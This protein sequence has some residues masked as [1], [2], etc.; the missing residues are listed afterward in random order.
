MSFRVPLW[1][2]DAFLNRHVAKVR[3][4]FSGAA[5]MAAAALAVFAVVLLAFNASAVASQ[6][7]SKLGGVT[8]NGAMWLALA[9]AE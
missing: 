3:F 7:A 9:T 4:L 5:G 8:A 1:N 2:P 6:A